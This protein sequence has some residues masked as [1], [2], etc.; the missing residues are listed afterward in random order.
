ML[1]QLHTLR[2]TVRKYSDGVFLFGTNSDVSFLLPP[3]YRPSQPRSRQFP[4]LARKFDL[5]PSDYHTLR[6]NTCNVFGIDNIGTVHTHEPVIKQLFPLGDTGPRAINRP[7]D[8]MEQHFRIVRFDINDGRKFQGHLPALGNERDIPRPRQPP[9]KPPRQKF[10]REHER[11]QQNEQKNRIGEQRGEKFPA[12]SDEGIIAGKQHRHP[13]HHH[14]PDNGANYGDTPTTTG[15]KSLRQEKLGTKH[16]GQHRR[17]DEQRPPEPVI[18]TGQ[19]RSQQQYR[20]RPISSYRPISHN[21]IVLSLP[22]PWQLSGKR[23]DSANQAIAETHLSS[24]KIAKSRIR[25]NRFLPNRRF[26]QQKRGIR[27]C[28]SAPPTPIFAKEN[29]GPLP[30]TPTRPSLF[31]TQKTIAK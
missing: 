2:G 8:R 3:R 29:H 9:P 24:A 7:V 12:E 27:L 30:K 14:G 17:C 21:L 6:S 20:H 31:Q 25:Q 16:T 28:N 26:Q 13:F 15:R 4:I 1:T 23:Q 22:A 18:E 11:H 19:Q 5:H 10:T